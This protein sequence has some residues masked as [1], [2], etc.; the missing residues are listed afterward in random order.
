[1]VCSK[2]WEMRHPQELIRP[3]P[4]QPKQPW[5]R[6]ESTDQYL[7]VDYDNLPFECS[8]TGVF[9]QADYATADC[10]IV[11]HTDGGLIP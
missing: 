5:T 6:P 10:A 3:L 4:E 8:L 2:D 1:M 7:T 9:C 11:G